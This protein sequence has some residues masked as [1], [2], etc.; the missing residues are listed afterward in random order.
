M[1]IYI[2]IYIYITHLPASQGSISEG[3]HPIQEM[4]FCS[5][6]WSLCVCALV[7]VSLLT[8]SPPTAAAERSR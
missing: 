5:V 1:Y 4:L 2:Y 7:P 8:S 6:Q 3:T